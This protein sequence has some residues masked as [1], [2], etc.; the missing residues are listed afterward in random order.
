MFEKLFKANATEK[1]VLNQINIFKLQ[2]SAW[3]IFQD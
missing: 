3:E 2:T 1:S